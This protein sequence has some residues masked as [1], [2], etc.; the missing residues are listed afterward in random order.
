VR[1]SSS[2][3][4]SAAI[5]QNGVFIGFLALAAAERTFIPARTGISSKKLRKNKKPAGNDTRRR[6]KWSVYQRKLEENKKAEL[7]CVHFCKRILTKLL[8]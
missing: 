2:S 8:R 5:F 7:G 6:R 1:V 4:C 3:L